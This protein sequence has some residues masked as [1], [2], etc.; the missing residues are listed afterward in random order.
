MKLKEFLDML[1]D[2]EL[3]QINYGKK[4]EKGKLIKQDALI[5]IINRGVTSLHSL[6]ELSKG[7]LILDISNKEGYRVDLTNKSYLLSPDNVNR[8]TKVIQIFN[9]CGQDVDFNTINRSN[10]DLGEEQI[11]LTNKTTL[12][13]TNCCGCYRI[14]FEY[15]PKLIEIKEEYDWDRE[16]ID[17]PIEFTSALVYYVAMNLHA[18]IPFKQEY[19]KETSP[20][21]QYSKKY[22][23]ELMI[24]KNMNI[25]IGGTGNSTQRFR[26]SSF[27]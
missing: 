9:P 16:E 21:I 13:F 20:A 19:A 15:S 8:I 7:E 10:C 23:E 25:E 5:R 3:S 4:D 12:S 18:I 11:Y 27:I 24:L 2:L 14:L 26:D 1:S 17:L 22:N 6:F